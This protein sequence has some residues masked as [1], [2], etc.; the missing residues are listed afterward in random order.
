MGLES[1]G[2]QRVGRLK[3]FTLLADGG[4]NLSPAKIQRMMRTCAA[5]RSQ[6]QHIKRECHHYSSPWVRLAW[7]LPDGCNILAIIP[8]G[9]DISNITDAYICKIQKKINR[10]KIILQLFFCIALTF[11]YFCLHIN[12]TIKSF[13]CLPP[14]RLYTWRPKA[15]AHHSPVRP[16]GGIYIVPEGI[17]QLGFNGEQYWLYVLWICIRFNFPVTCQ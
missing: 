14:P 15:S 12:S 5:S 10:K 1:L 3:D 9:I 7:A 11:H 4:H 13:L 6:K 8:K 16:R 2:W 17:L